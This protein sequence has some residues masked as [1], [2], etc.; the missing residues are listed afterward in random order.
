MRRYT[1]LTREQ[2]Y[3]IYALK[4]AGHSQN[5]IAELVEVHKSTISREL[6]RNAGQRGYRPKQAHLISQQRD[7]K[8]GHKRIRPETWFQIESRLKQLWS[9]K[10]ISGWL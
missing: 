7:K 10:Q 6:N 3:Q 1:Q 5:K 9:L 8:K 4:K 2:R